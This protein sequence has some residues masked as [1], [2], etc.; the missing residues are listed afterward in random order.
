MIDE[1]EARPDPRDH[2]ADGRYGETLFYDF[3]K[4]ATTMS[5]LTLGGVVSVIQTSPQGDIKVFN[6][7]VITLAIAAAASASFMAAHTLSDA[8]SQ[9]KEPPAYLRRVMSASLALLG[10]GLGGFMMMWIDSLG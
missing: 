8:R 1:N 3:A 4:F 2:A 6:I 10:V 7:L 5:L 9:G